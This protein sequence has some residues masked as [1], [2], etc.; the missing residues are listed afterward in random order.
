MTLFSGMG[1]LTHARPNSVVS[2]E[3]S[4]RVGRIG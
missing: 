3:P 1:E 4:D 2:A